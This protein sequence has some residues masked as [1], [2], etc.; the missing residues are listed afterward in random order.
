MTALESVDGASSVAAVVYLLGL[1]LK[2]YKACHKS[3]VYMHMDKI[4]A[5][6][7]GGNWV[8]LPIYENS[9]Q[10]KYPTEEVYYRM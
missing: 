5:S 1:V 7:R 2:R 10:M 9:P 8:I 3:P 6:T 4:R